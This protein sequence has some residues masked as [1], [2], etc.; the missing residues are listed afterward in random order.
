[1]LGRKKTYA[2]ALM[3]EAGAF[4]NE[5]PGYEELVEKS[6]ELVEETFFDHPTHEEIEQQATPFLFACIRLWMLFKDFG[7]PNGMIGWANERS[8]VI[9]IIQIFESESKKYD[10]WEWEKDRPKKE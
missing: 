9:E 7:L 3:E 2:D 4:A 10:R 5:L 6:G 1:M 8:T